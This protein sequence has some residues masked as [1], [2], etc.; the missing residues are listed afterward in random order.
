MSSQSSAVPQ[1][2]I[3]SLPEFLNVSLTEPLSSVSLWQTKWRKQCNFLSQKT[4]K[5]SHPKVSSKNNN[6][7]SLLTRIFFSQEKILP[8]SNPLSSRQ[9]CG[10]TIQVNKIAVVFAFTFQKWRV[11]FHACA[12]LAVDNDVDSCSFTPRTSDQRWWQ[13]SWCNQG[14]F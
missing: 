10:P 1:V 14:G 6:K 3:S 12:G 13:V 11:N 2:P 7:C 8:W 9:R 5:L 4:I